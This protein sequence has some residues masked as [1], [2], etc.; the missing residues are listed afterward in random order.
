MDGSIHEGNG[1]GHTRQGGSQGTDHRHD[2]DDQ[3][4][5]GKQRIEEESQGLRSNNEQYRRQIHRP[6]T[7]RQGDLHPS[8]EYPVAQ[9][10]YTDE[11][12]GGWQEF[13]HHRNAD[14]PSCRL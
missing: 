3:T 7:A 1:K 14:V 13:P 11:D 9:H 6:K 2:T 10:A 8:E 4:Q 12:K 5:D